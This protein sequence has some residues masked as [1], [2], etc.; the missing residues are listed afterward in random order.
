MDIAVER[1]RRWRSPEQPVARSFPLPPRPSLSNCKNRVLARRYIPPSSVCEPLLLLQTLFFILSLCVSPRN[2]EA[3]ELVRPRILSP[4]LSPR[5]PRDPLT[6]SCE[7]RSLSA[8]LMAKRRRT[9]IARIAD[10]A[11]RLVTYSKRRKGLFNKASDLCRLCG[12]R[13]AVVVFSPAGKPC[14]FGDPSADQII[15]DYLRGGGG[16]GGDDGEVMPPMGLTQWAEWVQTE[17]DACAT[18]EDLESLIM[19]YEAVRDCAREKLK[20]L[21]DDSRVKVG[22]ADSHELS[23]EEIDSIFESLKGQIPALAA[24]LTEGDG[25]STSPEDPAAG[26]GSLA[27]EPTPTPSDLGDYGFDPDDFLNLLEDFDG[28][29]D[30][31]LTSP[32][33]LAAGDGSL[34]VE[35]TPAP[36]DLGDYGFDPEDF[37]NLFEDFDGRGDGFLTS[38]EDSAA[39]DGSLAMEPTPAPSDLGD[40][41]FDPEDSLNL[42]EDFDGH[43]GG[44]LTSPEDSAVGG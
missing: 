14:S 10:P 26:D 4:S 20:A 2:P 9:E 30:G 12:A 3:C 43:G 15:S 25:F 18:E 27:V 19:K 17:W 16:G 11:A 31:F 6:D 34:A 39:G 21:E 33:D 13:A 37:L 44:F 29:G 23:D 5:N 35:P 24:L 1:R 7:F 41:G 8:S 42:F 32:E 36:S 28:H 40:Y 38:P 22:A